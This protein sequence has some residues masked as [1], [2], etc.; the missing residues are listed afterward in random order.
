MS[1]SHQIMV[2]AG[3]AENEIADLQEA[4]VNAILTEENQSAN[5]V[6]NH[7]KGMHDLSEQELWRR[8]ATDANQ[9]TRRSLSRIAAELTGAVVPRKWPSKCTL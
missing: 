4:L 3:V 7:A 6:K 2:D 1:L 9:L 5:G 8:Y